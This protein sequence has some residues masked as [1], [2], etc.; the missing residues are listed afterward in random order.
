MAGMYDPDARCPETAG[1]RES[2]L[3]SA[4]RTIQLGPTS[5][6]GR[7]TDLP[8]AVTP[9]S[10]VPL[11]CDR[12]HVADAVIHLTVLE[13]G[14]STV[15]HYC[16]DCARALGVAVTAVPVRPSGPNRPSDHDERA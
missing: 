4:E 12:C 5:C 7:A 3:P 8:I 16:V 9:M 15:E 14:G 6:S 13:R 2:H 11:I 1:A 10:R